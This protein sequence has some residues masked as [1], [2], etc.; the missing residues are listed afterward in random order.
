MKANHILLLLLFFMLFPFTTAIAQTYVAGYLGNAN[1]DSTGNPYIVI[2][3]VSIGTLVINPGVI[4]LF[5]SCAQIRIRELLTINGTANDSVYFLANNSNWRGIVLTEFVTNCINYTVFEGATEYVIYFST[6]NAIIK[7]STFRYNQCSED[8]IFTGHYYSRTLLFEKCDFYNNN[9][10]HVINAEPENWNLCLRECRFSN[11]ICNRTINCYSRY[12]E[13]FRCQFSHNTCNT[14]IWMRNGWVA[15]SIF[16]N[17]VSE[18]DTIFQVPYNALKRD[19]CNSIFWGSDT[20]SFLLG[21]VHFKYCDL[22][23]IEPGEGNICADPLFINPA[24][25]DFRLQNNSPCIDTGAPG[26]FWFDLD[27]TRADMGIGGGSGIYVNET[28]LS[29]Y[30]LQPTQRLFKRFELHNYTDSIIN[31]SNYQVSPPYAFNAVLDSNVINPNGIASFEIDFYN[32][33]YSCAGNLTVTSPQFVSNDTGTVNLF[34]YHG[35]L[36]TI[37]GRLFSSRSPYNFYESVCVPDGDSLLIEEGVWM[38]FTD[39]TFLYIEGNLQASGTNEEYGMIRIRSIDNNPWGGLVFNSADGLNILRYTE[40]NR[41][42]IFP[43]T[44]MNGG[45]IYAR[46]T[47]LELNNCMFVYCNTVVNTSGYGNGG[48]IYIE[49]CDNVTIDSTRILGAAP[50]TADYGG[51]LYTKG[52]PN[53]VIRNSTFD[54]CA[55]RHRGGSIYAKNSAIFIDSTWINSSSQGDAGIF[56]YLDSSTVSLERSLLVSGGGAGFGTASML[57]LNNSSTATL[58]HCDII[59]SYLYSRNLSMELIDPNSHATLSNSIIW[60]TGFVTTRQ[61]QIQMTYSISPTLW[62]GEGNLAGDPCVNDTFRLLMNSPCIDA[63]D[64]NYPL[65]P[66]STRTDM[67]AYYYEGGTIIA[68]PVSGT[69]NNTATPYV[70]GGNIVVL[71]GDTLLIMPGVTVNF[72]GNHSFNVYGVLLIQGQIGN[73]VNING[74]DGELNFLSTQGESV[75]Q[76]CSLQQFETINLG[77]SPTHFSNVNLNPNQTIQADNSSGSTMEN[78]ILTEGIYGGNNWTINGCSFNVRG[79]GYRVASA[80]GISGAQGNFTN[81]R[82]DIYSQASGDVVYEGSIGFMNCSGVFEGNYIYVSTS[83]RWDFSGIRFCS[84]RCNNNIIKSNFTEAGEAGIYGFNGECYNN[85]ITDFPRGMA[86]ISPGPVLNTIVNN[87]RY[88]FMIGALTPYEIRYCNVFNCTTPYSTSVI[89]GPGNIQQNPLFQQNYQLSPHSPCIDAGDPDP[90]YNDPDST[91]SEIGARYYHQSPLTSVD[92][93]LTPRNPP[94]Q[95]PAGGGS[96]TCDFTVVNPDCVRG[97]FDGWIKAELPNGR[98]TGPLIL[99]R[100]VSLPPGANPARTLTQFVPHY[101]PVGNYQYVGYVGG[102]PGTVIDSA[103]FG[104][105]KLPG[106]VFQPAHNQGWTLTG[107]GETWSGAFAVEPEIP[108][109]YAFDS[110]YPN[111]FNQSVSLRFSLPEAGKVSLMVYDVTGREVTKL[112]DDWRTAGTYTEIWEAKGFSSGV[113]F[114]V[115][116]AGGCKSVRKMLLVK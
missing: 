70:V 48:A 114:V 92:M 62:P 23:V 54:Y 72:T 84:G 11:N 112:T 9:C 79:Y 45:G 94:I 110:P 44:S 38:R 111:P 101:A 20:S 104:F 30:S 43:I 76:Y 37:S 55:A 116:K 106:D 95:I 17:A 1:W 77:S 68:G 25:G 63:G 6:S 105:E 42:K 19:I 18:S 109:E 7:N 87:C 52:C 78:C 115:F 86:E 4:V 49:D 31:I 50:G 98:I 59:Q 56:V 91:R 28:Q 8:I 108:V 75:L 32:P 88:G 46:N 113:Y 35:R 51:G 58:D 3:D 69:W 14:S 85:T 97:F 61:D 81:N 34:G 21:N 22:P 33:G 57:A 93:N 96:F 65:D 2:G 103:S 100:F 13:V 16:Y 99:R 73:L 41:A 64:P 60:P 74:G 39:S 89:I 71:A 40:I 83:C 47:E 15:S 67:G 5:D 36:M 80:T 66:D 12:L 90:R 24:I 29:F 102:H 10:L 26:G 82:F 27:S 53:V 107:W